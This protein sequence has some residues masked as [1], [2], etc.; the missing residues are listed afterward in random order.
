MIVTIDGPAGAGKSSLARD[1]ARKLGFRFLNTGAMYRAVVLAA[2]ERQVPWDDQL[3]LEQL[4]DQLQLEFRDET[5]LIDGRD[6]TD[7]IRSPEVSAAIHFVADNA[8]IR[9]RL[10]QWQREWAACGDVVTEGRDQGTDAFPDADCK[11]FLIASPEVRAERRWRQLRQ[12]QPD[13]TLEQ[14]LADQQLRDQ[15]DIDRPCGGLREPKGSFRVSTDEMSLA[16]AVDH[17]ARIVLE[18]QARTAHEA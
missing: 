18:I 16:E 4:V 6:V 3:Q 14:V 8:R 12:Q 9:R 2:L 5:V 7:P 15:R 13:L 11:I 10:I 1:L 17:V